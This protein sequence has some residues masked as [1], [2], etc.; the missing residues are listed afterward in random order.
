MELCPPLDPDGRTA[1]VA[2]L[3]FLSFVA[4][5]SERPR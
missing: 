1:R 2:A 4:G 5:F 3:L